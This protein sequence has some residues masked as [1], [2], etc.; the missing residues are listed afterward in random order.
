MC[1]YRKGEQAAGKMAVDPDPFQNTRSLE[2]EAG[3]EARLRGAMERAYV[4]VGAGASEPL[5]VDNVEAAFSFLRPWD[6]DQADRGQ[7]VRDVLVQ[8]AKTILRTVPPSPMRTRALNHLI[9]AR[10]L[11]DAGIMF[12]G[13]F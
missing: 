12:R 7:Q 13:R 9:D 10:M 5:T 3:R 4:A 2:T 6:V 11:A 1:D 8:A